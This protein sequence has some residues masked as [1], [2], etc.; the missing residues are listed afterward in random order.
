MTQTRDNA[1]PPDEF[2]A[3]RLD[4]KGLG[5]IYLSTWPY[6]YAQLRHFLALLALN[7]GMIGFATAFGFM[8]FDILWDSVGSREPLSQAQAAVMFVPEADFVAVATLTESARMEILFR[9]LIVSAVIII[10]TTSAFTLISV[11]KTWILQRVNQAL[12]VDMVRNAEELS[13]RFHA[14]TSAGDGIYRVFQDSAMVTAVVDN[15]VVQPIIALITLMLQLAIAV[16]FS[17]WFAFLLC[18]ASGVVISLAIW[19][20]PRLRT[21][22]QAAR[23]SNAVLFTRVQETFQSIQAIKAYQFE[24]TNLVRFEQESQL[25]LDNAFGLRRDFAIVK[26]VASFLLAVTLFATDYIATQFVLRDDMVF[27]ASLL[28]LFGMTV[29]RW[30]VAAHQARRG[31]VAAF[32]FSFENLVRLWCFAQDMAVGLGRAFWLLSQQPEVRDPIDPNAF[33]EAVDRV[34]FESVRFG[35]EPRRPVLNGFDLTARVGQVTA[36]V[37]TSGAGKST[38]MALLLRLF[39]PDEGSVQINGISLSRLQIN[40]IRSAV[41]IALQENV[42]FPISIADNLRYTAPNATDEEIRDAAAVACALEF[43]DELPNGFETELGIGGALLSV[44]QKQRLSIARTLTRNAPILILD[45]PTSSLDAETEERLLA[46]LK[47]WAQERV[48][49]VITHRISTIKDV[50]HIAFLA[51]GK[52]VEAGSHEELMN[53]SGYYA[54]FVASAEVIHV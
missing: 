47:I 9:F 42:L 10:L 36:L 41:A 45:E 44:G 38:A 16:L 2:E 48:V 46:N 12:R 30:T 21:W 32:T 19:Y 17:P 24:R 27:G 49:F 18:V 22:S 54:D 53:Q 26:V 7:L 1:T 34:T 8:S 50:D 52:V 15:V 14:T 35:Y 25:A 28:V 5:R 6:I 40:E 39:D 3:L 33:P 11:Y 37:G 51:E 23:R 20:T 43:I 31:A 13:L 4:L 29:T